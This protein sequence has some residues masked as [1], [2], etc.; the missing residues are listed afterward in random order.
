MVAGDAV[1]AGAAE[2]VPVAVAKVDAIAELP[3]LR[4]I[5]PTEVAPRVTTIAVMRL[6]LFQ[7]IFRR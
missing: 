1:P 4:P 6:S 3:E 2:A 5:I 7:F